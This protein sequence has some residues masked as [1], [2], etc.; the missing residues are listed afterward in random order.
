MKY[1]FIA[2][3]T[4]FAAANQLGADQE[5]AP[6]PWVAVSEGGQFIFKLIPKKSHWEGKLNTREVIDKEAFGVAYAINAEGEF[7]ELWR[8][9]GWHASDGLLSS[10][11][12]YFI[13]Y[14]PWAQDLENQSDLAIGFYD[15]GRLLQ[16][17]TVKDLIKNTDALLPSASHYW[18]KA[19]V[20]SKPN[21]FHEFDEKAFHLVM[22]DKTAYDFEVATGKILKTAVDPGARSRREVWAEEEAAAERKGR[23]LYDTCSFKKDFDEHFVFSKME[24]ALGKIYR[25]HVEGPEW[26]A[27]FAPKKTYALACEVEAVFPIKEEKRIANSITSQEI[28]TAFQKAFAHPFIKE[29]IGRGASAGLRLR[30]TDD[31]LHWDTVDVRAFLKQATAVEPDDGDTLRPWAEFLLDG[32][33]HPITSYYLNTETGDL[34]HEVEGK[35]PTEHILVDAA[36]VSRGIL[37]TKSKGSK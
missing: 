19:E 15:R 28:D 17:Y 29:R 26:R 31:R 9:K 22:I 8:T 10:D 12:R 13:R 7:E 36:G 3:M 34:I 33:S 16:E 1:L 11:G 32:K 23:Q 5:L 21:G 35:W 24:A 30:I 20:Q 4:V 27:N 37:S 25:T 14:G 18:W 6:S 2:F